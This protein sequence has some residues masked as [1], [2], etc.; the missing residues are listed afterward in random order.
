MPTNK[1]EQATLEPPLDTYV[2]EAATYSL[3]LRAA[4]HSPQDWPLWGGQR[5][6]RGVQTTATWDA[7]AL[8]KRVL[9]PDK[10]GR[11]S[12]VP[13][14]IGAIVPAFSERDQGDQTRVHLVLQT[15]D[16]F[17]TVKRRLRKDR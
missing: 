14:A 16:S 4:Q 2:G 6:R 12:V 10:I 17:E 7:R 5:H 8:A 1:G 15:A 13:P 9:R 3:T 11:E